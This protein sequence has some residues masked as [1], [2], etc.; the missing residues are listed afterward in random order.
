MKT[1]LKYLVALLAMAFTFASC[2][3]DDNNNTNPVNELDG[4]VKIQQFD[5]DSHTI[6]L[7]SKT[8]F[9]QQGFNDINIR[10]KDK[11]STEYIKN[12][13]ITWKPIMHMTMMSH[14]CPFSKVTKLTSEGTLYNG[15]IVFTMPQN[16]TEY[17]DLEIK[18]TINGTEFTA[19]SQIDVP[20]SAKRNLNTFTGTDGTK[21]IVAY[22]EPNQP[23]VA[24]ND[25]KVGVWKMENMMSYPM[26][27]GYTVKIDPRMPSMGN[28]TS[29][30]NVNATQSNPGEL[31]NGKLA[32]TMT[33][34]WKINL[35]LAN[36]EG[37][38]LKG[39]TIT[40]ANE[41]SSIFFEIEF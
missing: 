11:Q 35:Q 6:E 36:A 24:I 39:E 38:V 28:H 31:Y 37:E 1:S 21:Y 34:Y 9:L 13:A 26:V 41:A 15:Y 12:A 40:E 5:N 2:S 10:I 29:P 4:L 14:A 32:L 8:G 19:L 7:Y 33:G 30:N 18:Y 27:N 25:L 23:K 16:D 22:I 17:W 20:A 3:S